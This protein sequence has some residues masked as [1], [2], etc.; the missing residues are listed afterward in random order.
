MKE[1]SQVTLKRLPTS[2]STTTGSTGL[3]GSTSISIDNKSNNSIK[4]ID[5]TD[6]DN[7]V[8]TSDRDSISFPVEHRHPTPGLCCGCIQKKISKTAAVIIFLL[9]AVAVCFILFILGDTS[10]YL[11]PNLS[12][13]SD[14]MPFR[15]GRCFSMCEPDDLSHRDDKLMKPIVV[16]NGVS[17]TR[18]F[19][20][21]FPEEPHF[22]QEEVGE[23]AF[24][25][26]LLEAGKLEEA[27]Q[28]SRVHLKEWPQ[29]ESYAGFFKVNE[30]YNSH[31]YFWFFPSQSK[32]SEDPVILWLQGGPGATSLFGLFKENG[33]IK[34]YAVSE[35][36]NPNKEDVENNLNGTS[37]KCEHDKRNSRS[38]PW[39]DPLPEF[40]RY[41][42]NQPR[43]KLNPYSWNRNASVIYIDNPVGT[44]FSFTEAQEGY[45]N[46][47]NQSSEELFKGLQQFFQLLPEYKDRDF[48]IFGESYGGKYVPSLSHR[49][50][51][52]KTDP[53][54]FGGAVD[55]NLVGLGIG[56]GWMSPLEQ[57]K[58]AS[59]LYYHGLLDGDQYLTLLNLEED[60][61]QKISKQEW[62]SSWLASDQ[63]LHFVL[64]SLN[65]SS[66]YD[67][68]RGQFSLG[69]MDFW[70][71][72]QQPHVR[73][74]MKLGSRR[75][76]DGLEIY[77]AMIEDTMQSIRPELVEAMENYKVL[78]YHGALDIICHFP[79]AQ[80]MLAT[81]N[82]KGKEEFHKSERKA[83]W[84]YNEETTKQDLAGYVKGGKDSLK[85]V[86]ILNAGHSAPMDQPQWTLRM[87][88]A[89]I[90]DQLG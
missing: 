53:D 3:N 65:Y 46:F 12:T 79:G 90:N 83:L 84:L 9:I 40:P 49:I 35:S 42:K 48:Y 58:Y 78:I 41:D 26:P 27:R 72:M 39:I 60:L 2:S 68:T 70:Y 81:T 89:F 45:P 71:W 4:D 63:Q 31:L 73:K 67:F 43:S 17:P 23:P 86:L 80:E 52:S 8:F 25:T 87:V 47:V 74:S 56:N 57:G 5:I 76:S 66:L 77:K 59:Y 64:Q 10:K 7:N 38:A 15:E 69:G 85:L 33:P 18:F 13:T 55:I 20:Y 88:E 61:T 50:H 24:L 6:Q 21:L 37:D 62:F 22:N 11:R 36:D 44:G 16:H 14:M 19:L 30:T 51:K 1:S 54:N 32:P 75:M 82:W 28:R 29:M 34:A